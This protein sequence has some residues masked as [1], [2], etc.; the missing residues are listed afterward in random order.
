MQYICSSIH[1]KGCLRCIWLRRKW[2]VGI[3]WL[4]G[5]WRYCLSA[6]KIW[7]LC[8][9]WTR[10]IWCKF[11]AY[12]NVLSTELTTYA[13]IFRSHEEATFIVVTYHIYV[14]IVKHIRYLRWNRGTWCSFHTTYIIIEVQG[15]RCTNHLRGCRLIGVN[16]HFI[17]SPLWELMRF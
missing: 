5:A 15:I 4:F 8:S 6:S 9:I 11:V 14:I 17:P 13:F 2:S 12:S 3:V 7:Q 16:P 10:K 1:K